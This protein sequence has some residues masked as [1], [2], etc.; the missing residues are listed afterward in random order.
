MRSG[1]TLP[2]RLY[3]A[4]L[5]W[6]LGRRFL[7]LHHTGR[8]S[9]R[10]F[11]VVLEVVRYDRRSGEATVISGF[12]RDADWFRNVVAGGPVAVDFGHGPRPAV[13][14]VLDRDEA[15]RAYA[16]YEGRNV[17]IGPL[18]RW[19]LTKLLGWRY[20]GSPEARRRMVE[21]LP[22]V[23]VRPALPDQTHDFVRVD[24]FRAS[25]THKT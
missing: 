10:T 24:P 20:D 9:G 16:S 23:A 12:G 1:F 3:D 21:E 8:R 19:T 14:R 18:V 11:Q 22:L 13:Y 4:G 2:N 15:Q 25:D 5:G 7:R 17:L 6:L